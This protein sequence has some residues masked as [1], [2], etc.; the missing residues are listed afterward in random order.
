MVSSQK[1]RSPTMLETSSINNFA[2]RLS[3]P[4]PRCDSVT[5]VCHKSTNQT[6]I[7]AAGGHKLSSVSFKLDEKKPSTQLQAVPSS[8]IDATTGS[9]MKKK[10]LRINSLRVLP[11]RKVLL[12]GSSNGKVHYCI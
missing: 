12:L 4:V 1:R 3:V 10:K 8:L 6:I 2:S 7:Y 5:A 11:L 9:K